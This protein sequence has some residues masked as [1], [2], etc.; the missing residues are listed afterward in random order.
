MLTELIANASHST[1][2]GFI[3]VA[4]IAVYFCIIVVT[5]GHRIRKGAHMGHDHH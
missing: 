3:G 2:Q 1:T 4:L 5:A